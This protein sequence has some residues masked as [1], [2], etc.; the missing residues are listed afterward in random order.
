MTKEIDCAAVKIYIKPLKSDD[1][2]SDLIAVSNLN[3]SSF[4]TE[5]LNNLSES[6]EYLSHIEF[7]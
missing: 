5:K 4:D 1:Q 7:P 2:Q 6:F 3:M